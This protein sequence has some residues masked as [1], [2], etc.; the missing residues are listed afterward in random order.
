MKAAI[1]E[2]PGILN[3]RDVPEPEPG[4]YDALCRNLYASTCS[5][6]DLHLVHGRFPK[7]VVYPTVLGHETVGRVVAVGPRVRHLDLGDLMTRSGTSGTPPPP[8]TRL[9]SNWGGYAE[10]GTVTDHRAMR[11]DSLDEATWKLRTAE[12]VVPPD[13]EP[14]VATMLITW[15]E[16]LSYLKRMGVSRGATVL[17]MG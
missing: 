12:K 8:G 5:G 11:E 4:E 14:A 1:V 2:R 3:V 16:T 15:R 6:T 9:A 13:V 17:L 7:H 10:Y